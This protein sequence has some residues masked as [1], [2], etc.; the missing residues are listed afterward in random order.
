MQILLAKQKR[1]TQ[2]LNF[3][4]PKKKKNKCYK[5]QRERDFD[6]RRPIDPYDAIRREAMK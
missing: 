1:I 5:A 4:Y 6:L 2:M 3:I